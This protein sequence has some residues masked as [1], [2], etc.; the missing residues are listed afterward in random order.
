MATSQDDELLSIVG[1]KRRQHHLTEAQLNS[2]LLAPRL[3]TQCSRNLWRRL[4]TVRR[5][6]C[7]RG[8]ARTIHEDQGPNDKHHA[9]ETSTPAS[10]STLS[11]IL[12]K[13]GSQAEA[14]VKL[15]CDDLK[16]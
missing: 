9:N 2:H 5:D 13:P 15:R 7:Q 16:A 14:T 4:C 10:S 6:S 3:S 1:L 12:W 11:S 8:A